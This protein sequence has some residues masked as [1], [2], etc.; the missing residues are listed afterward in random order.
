MLF[1]LSACYSGQH[2]ILVIS[3]VILV[4]SL[5]FWPSGCQC[6]ILVF[7]TLFWSSVRYSGLQY[8]ILVLSTLFWSSVH[9]SGCQYVILVTSTLFWSPE[10]YSGHQYVI[11]V[12][13]TLYRSSVCYSA[14]ILL[15]LFFLSFL[16]RLWMDVAVYTGG[17][18][19]L[20]AVQF[21]VHW[22]TPRRLLLN[23]HQTT[24]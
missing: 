9:Y 2:V 14:L 7:S 5:L 21:F 16:S 8:V 10:H 4:V 17:S 23:P 22:N 20:A 24:F 3:N 12:I 13:S 15:F 18:S 1:L 11:L 19:G 6:A